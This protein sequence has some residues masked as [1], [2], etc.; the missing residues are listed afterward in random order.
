M[1][2]T[3][4]LMHNPDSETDALLRKSTQQADAGDWNGAIETLREAKARLVESHVHYPVETWCKLGLYLSRAGRF[5]ES[6]AEFDWLLSDLPRRARKESFMDDRSV[7]FGK[8]TSKKSVY[9]AIVRNTRRI[10]EEK[11]AV[12]LRRRAAA[13]PKRPEPACRASPARCRS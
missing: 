2:I 5:D 10:V 12:A 9:N 1:E 8:A 11:R 4:E 13:P 6:M 3:V 7:S